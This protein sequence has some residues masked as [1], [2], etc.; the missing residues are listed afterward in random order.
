VLGTPS[1]MPPEQAA[2][3]GQQ[4]G[5][6]ADVYALGAILYECLTGRPPFL[7]ATPLDTLPQVVGEEPVPPRRLQSKVPR[8]LETICLKCLQK[9]PAKRYA[10]AEALAD[11]LRRFRAGEP[12]RAQPVGY[13]ERAL[14]WARRRPAVAALLACVL[15]LAATAG[16]FA[17]RSH[18]A[19]QHRQAERRQHALDTALLLA[20]GGDLGGAEQAI[21]EAELLGASAGDVRLARGQIA[22]YRGDLHAA[23]EQLEQAIRLQPERVAPR[24]LLGA[25]CQDFGYP[26]RYYELLADLDGLTAVT[27]EDYL[28]KGLVQ[29]LESPDRGLAAMDEAIR[30]R[31]SSVARALR[32]RAR[33]SVAMGTGNPS[34]AVLA[35]EDARVAKAML[36]DNPFAL[37]QCVFAHLVAVGA[38]ERHDRRDEQRAALAHA[39]RDVQALERVRHLPVASM[40]RGFYFRIAGDHA[41]ALEEWHH[42]RRSGV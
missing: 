23:I 7:A 37:A 25:A 34:D 12:I 19:E 22:F 33:A 40:A 10:S 31:D 21:A 5:P 18:R 35:L 13:A 4:V 16:F 26:E 2:G 6:A 9:E 15:G 17:Y 24:A 30:R 20:L 29:S 32:A 3:K 38:F 39:A 28:F 14:K 11:D 41:A 27:A 1:Y 36:P 42:R 8:D